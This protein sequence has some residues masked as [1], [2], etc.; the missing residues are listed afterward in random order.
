MTTSMDSMMGAA[1]V[2]PTCGD[3]FLPLEPF[4]AMKQGTAHKIP[5]I[6][7]TNADEGRLFTRFLKL[8]PTTEH[9]IERMLAH[10]PPEVRQRILAA[11]PHYPHP[12]AC[13]QF[14]GDM[15]FNTAAWQI[16][17]AHAKLAPTYVYRYDFAPR[18]LHWTGLG[19]TH[20]TELLAVF[21]IYRSRVGAVLTA[22]V[23]QRAAVK[24]SHQVQTRWHEFA[25]TGVPGDDWPV[26]NS[27]DRPVLVFDRHTHVEYDPH[28][29]RRE[30]WAGFSLAER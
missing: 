14:G 17:E 20:A 23:D 19:A 18:T 25:S 3:D 27:I 10:S 24:V 1:P 11:Y 6:V 15:I 26:Y 9:A 29:H 7:G 28:P 2:G 16:A 8:L 4:D 30:A 12:D 5:L 22:G 21:G 13:V